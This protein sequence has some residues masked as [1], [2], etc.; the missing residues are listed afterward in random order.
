MTA[1]A[2]VVMTKVQYYGICDVCQ[3]HLKDA[4]FYGNLIKLIQYHREY[5]FYISAKRWVPVYTLFIQ[6]SGSG[7]C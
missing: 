1:L 4:I 6:F 2:K 7:C 5:Q 3:V